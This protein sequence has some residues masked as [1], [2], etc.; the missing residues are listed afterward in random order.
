MPFYLP[1]PS[2]KDATFRNWTTSADFQPATISYKNVIFVLVIPDFAFPKDLA[3]I[4]DHKVEM[5]EPT[6]RRTVV[7]GRCVNEDGRGKVYV[8]A[9]KV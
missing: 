1:S 6:Q 7:R 8:E 4:E 2:S 5:V 9:E 3:M